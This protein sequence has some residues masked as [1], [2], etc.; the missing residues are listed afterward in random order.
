MNNNNLE[1]EVSTSDL[2]KRK[3]ADEGV[4]AI[5]TYGELCVRDDL[6]AEGARKEATAYFESF[7][8]RRPYATA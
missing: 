4:I 7:F 5:L 2:E 3:R 6:T 8:K 1:Q